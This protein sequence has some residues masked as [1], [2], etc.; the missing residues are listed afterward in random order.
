MTA[1][2]QAIDLEVLHG[3][4]YAGCFLA[5]VLTHDWFKWIVVRKKKK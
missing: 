2:P 1:L 5:G 3:F 4:L